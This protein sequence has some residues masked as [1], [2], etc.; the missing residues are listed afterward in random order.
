[1]DKIRKLLQTPNSKIA[2]L[3]YFNLV[4]LESSLKEAQKNVSSKDPGQAN[5]QELLDELDNLLNLFRNKEKLP[6]INSS[7]TQATRINKKSGSTYVSNQFKLRELQKQFFSDQTLVPYLGKLQS[8]S[9]TDQELWQEFNLLL[10]RL[11]DN[12]AKSWQK[13]AI[14]IVNQVGAKE[15]NRSLIKLPFCRS[16]TIY[17]GLN[18]A[19]NLQGLGFSE[20]VNFDESIT[21]NKDDSELYLLGGIVSTYLKIIELDSSLHHAFKTVNRFTVA[22][23]KEETE[24]SRYI[25]ALIRCFKRYEEAKS[26]SEPLQALRSRLD[27]DEAI[28]SLV[29][30]PPADSTSWWGK[31][32]QESRRRLNQIAD[33]AREAGHNISIRSLAG[34]Y[35]DICQQS[36]DDLELELGGNP[37]EVLTCLRVYAKIDQEEIPGRVL[38]RSR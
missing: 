27:L 6:Q 36:R 33:K 35:A 31:L 15:D 9:K 37:G 16:E 32:Q 3:L 8:Q 22:S 28:H 4:G 21:K 23:L 7:K 2:N 25:K 18:G 20:Q 19:V 29:F 10:L 14:E 38:Y 1:M 17:P 12:I 13:Q 24:R 26:Q 30:N 11:P 34:D 5:C